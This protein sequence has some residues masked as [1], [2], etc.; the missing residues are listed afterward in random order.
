MRRDSS[1]IRSSTV[2]GLNWQLEM[3]SLKLPRRREMQPTPPR[4]LVNKLPSSNPWRMMMII[5]SQGGGQD[6]LT[7]RQYAG[8][9]LIQYAGSN[10]D[11][12]CWI[13]PGFNMLDLT[14]FNMPDSICWIQPGFNLPDL[15]WFQHAG[16]NLDS[17]CRIQPGL[18]MQDLTC[19]NMLDPTW[20]QY[21]GSNLDSIFR[22]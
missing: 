11:S 1:L 9:N 2:S 18:N 14:W 13:Q 4:Q 8:S 5:K 20:F 12:I 21:A 16:S 7:W 15:T 17:I 3:S 19:F 6:L 10:L 22:I